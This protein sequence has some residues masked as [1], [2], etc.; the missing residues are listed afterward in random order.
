M[1]TI[2]QYFAEL[3][4][5]GL[6]PDWKNIEARLNV[7]F[8]SKHTTWF[9]RVDNGYVGWC[10]WQVDNC[11]LA[12]GHEVIQLR[13]DGKD[14][15]KLA[16]RRPTKN[17]VGKQCW[18]LSSGVL[19]LFTLEDGDLSMLAGEPLLLA[20]NGRLCPEISDFEEVYK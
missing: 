16:W 15:V 18:M 19:S 5:A 7:N 11:A 2:Q 4:A 9:I 14:L 13:K 6:A 3:V 8:S 17:D 10:N 12:G 20:T 1:K